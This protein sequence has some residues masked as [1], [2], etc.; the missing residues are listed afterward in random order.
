MAITA[1]DV[2]VAANGDIR[3]TGAGA[4]DETQ[5]V[6]AEAIPADTPATGTIRVTDDLGFERWIPYSSWSGSTFTINSN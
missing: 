3:C 2:S 6:V 4:G 1:G 5:V